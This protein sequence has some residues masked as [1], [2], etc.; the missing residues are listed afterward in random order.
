MSGLIQKVD[1][2]QQVAPDAPAPS[3][4]ESSAWYW[5]EGMPGTGERPEW[6]KGKYGKV[7]DQAKAYLDA[8]KR[9]GTEQVSSAPDD[10]DWGEYKDLFD[11]ENPHLADLKNK[12]KDLRL[13][14]DAFKALVDPFANYHKSLMPDTDAEIAKLGPH[15]DMKINT[16]N[17]WASNHLSEK[18]L[19][20][21]GQIS[22]TAEVVELMDE[23]RQIHSQTLSKVPTNI[24][25][26]SRTIIVTPEQVQQKIVENYER[27]QKDASYR[28]QLNNEMKQA[29]GED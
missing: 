27:Y 18:A 1:V 17:T 9:L 19:T 22:N 16:V 29:C 2:S 24:Q 7:V 23:I 15:A 8:E 3:A 26:D 20:T 12:A 21:L 25:A 14:Q 10:Y 6:L 5:D 11:V 28:Q 4:S 13:S